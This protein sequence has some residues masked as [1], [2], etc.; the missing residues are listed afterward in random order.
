MDNHENAQK[1]AG[2]L[3]EFAAQ[4]AKNAPDYLSPEDLQ[5]LIEMPQKKASRAMW[6]AVMQ[7][8]GPTPK[9]LEGFIVAGHYGWV[10]PDINEYNFPVSASNDEG[11][12]TV[13]LVDY[14]KAVNPIH[15]QLHDLAHRGLKVGNLLDL[16][17]YVI[18]N[19]NNQGRR[20]IVELGSIWVD[21]TGHK[22]A[23]CH[24]DGGDNGPELQMVHAGC[25]N[26]DL[27]CSF[28]VRRYMS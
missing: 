14:D 1:I 3:L 15:I 8:L 6:K 13:E 25:C 22:L 16:V 27:L 12:Y 18:K 19:P 5:K 28:I 4:L 17:K 11:R 7:L 24:I 23:V 26:A 2:Q 9:L 20:A 21:P 10:D